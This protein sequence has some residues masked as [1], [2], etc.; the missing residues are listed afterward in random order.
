MAAF[1]T[2]C[3]LLALAQGE[4][5]TEELC[6]H[7]VA[8]QNDEQ[9]GLC[10]LQRGANRL[11]PPAPTDAHGVLDTPKDVEAS[12]LLLRKASEEA[13]QLYEEQ[14]EALALTK[15]RS[16]LL[17]NESMQ[18]QQKLVH[19][20]EKVRETQL[21]Y[22]GLGMLTPELQ[23]NQSIVSEAAD[24]EQ[25]REEQLKALAFVKDQYVQLA[26]QSSEVELEF[27]RLQA[28]QKQSELAYKGLA[29]MTP[30][31]QERLHHAAG[32]AGQAAAWLG[33]TRSHLNH[34]AHSGS[35]RASAWMQPQALVLVLV[36]LGTVTGPSISL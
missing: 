27:S 4:G 25:L 36:L 14:L 13:S 20:Q 34:S 33:L 35:R 32:A 9:S 15:E 18:L 16:A 12:Y 5:F 17:T 2:S 6:H 29:M 8:R 31:V 10:L 7:A 23:E 19:L 28:Q 30:L 22:K 24:H 1:A 21:A 11:D 26:N 3:M